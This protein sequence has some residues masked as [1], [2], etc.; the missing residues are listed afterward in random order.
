M[1]RFFLPPACTQYTVVACMLLP[2]FLLVLV[3]LPSNAAGQEA[4]PELRLTEFQIRSISFAGNVTFDGG[5]LSEVIESRATPG[6]ISQFFYNTFSEKLGSKPEFFSPEGITNDKRL[7]EDYYRDRGFYHTVVHDSVAVDTSDKEVEI[8][9]AIMENARSF[10]DSIEYAGLDSLSEEIRRWIFS[11]SV[12]RKGIPYETA[13]ITAEITRILSILVNNGYPTARFD[14][15]NY[16]AELFLSTNN[17][18]LNFVFHTGK[19]YSFGNVSVTVDPPR[20]DI[21]DNLSVRHLE[22]EPGEK[23]SREKMLVSE[24]NLNRLSLFEAARVDHPPVV[25]TTTSQTVPVSILVRPRPRNELSPEVIVSNENDAF[26]I[27]LGLG[28]TNR[29]FLGDGRSFNIRARGRTQSI[30]EIFAGNSLRDT[31]IIG[32][33]DLQLQVVQPYLFT[34]TLSGSLTGELRGEKYRYYILSIVRMRPGL[35]KKFTEYTYGTF[36]WTLERVRPEFLV[37]TTQLRSASVQLGEEDQEQFNSIL[38]FTLQSDHTDNPFSPTGGYFRSVSLEES[39][40]LPKLVA[41]GLPFTQYYKMTLLGRWY[42]DM[43]NSRY[44]ILAVKMRTGFQDKYGE[45][46]TKDVRIPLNRRFFAGGS[47]S[48]RGWKARELGAMSNDLLQF[49][50]NFALEGTAELRVNHLRGFGKFLGLKMDNIWGVYFIDVGNVWGDIGDFRFSD[51]SIAAGFGFRY[52]TF[53]GPFRI[54]YGF[55]VYD[56]KE[57]GARQTIFHKRFFGDTLGEGVLHFG[58]GHAF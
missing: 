57:D 20:D 43:S 21:T 13:V 10:I 1:G 46:K 26:N 5:R 11:E 15:D 6:S 52:E 35:N 4:T 40:I 28:Y 7:L 51:I 50:G 42:H 12:I 47:G 22:F 37:D 41:V 9:F 49:G 39:G 17:F 38:T 30:R 16:L 27:G 8:H 54:D 23:Y 53:F 44:S 56:P 58:I 36:D 32:S 14:Y 24:Q 3:F 48:V 25:D 18:H 34:K 19:Q 33:V 55:R 2:A 29:N 31:T 45:S